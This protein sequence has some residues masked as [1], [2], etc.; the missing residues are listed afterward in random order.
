MASPRNSCAYVVYLFASE[1][2]KT[3][4]S[5]TGDRTK[6]SVEIC[7][8]TPTKTADQP[9]TKPIACVREIAPRGISRAA[10]LGFSAS[11]RASTSRLKPIAAE[12]AATMAATIQPARPSV[13]GAYCEASSTPTRANGSANTEWLNLTNEA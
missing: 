1:Y 12:R 2:Q 8:V 13:T 9:A 6:Q 4:A 5:A 11:C 7:D 10:V 3:I